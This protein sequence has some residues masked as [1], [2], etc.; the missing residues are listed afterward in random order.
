MTIEVA[1]P[2]V[3]SSLADSSTRGMIDAMLHRLEM[4]RP[5]NLLKQRFYDFDAQI[6][7]SKVLPAAWQEAKQIVGWPSTVVDVLEE[8]LDL[9][10][11]RGD[12]TGHLQALMDDGLGLEVSLAHLDALIYGISFVAVNPNAADDAE[13]DLV[14]AES[15]LN[16]TGIL[17]GRG[18]RLEAAIMV[19]ERD[20]TTRAPRAIVWADSSE[21]GRLRLVAGVWRWEDRRPHRLGVTPVVQL[22]NRPRASRL[23]GR[24]EISRPIRAYTVQSVQTLAGMSAN[25]DF[26]S[27]PQRWASNAPKDAFTDPDTGEDIP[28]WVTAM[29]AMLSMSSPGPGQPETRFGSFAT[30]PPGPF[31]DQIEGLAKQVAGEAAIP[32]H[33]LGMLTNNT[34]SAEAIKN[35]ESRLVKRTERR[36]ATFGRSWNQV[37]R[38]VLAARGLSAGVSVVWRAADTP[39]V[40]AETDAVVKLVQA[41]VLPAASQVTWDRLRIS[42]ADQAQLRADIAADAGPVGVL[43]SALGRQLD[44]GRAGHEDQG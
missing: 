17:D 9:L 38:M 11:W 40:A 10:G 29:A 8:R 35:I 14:T 24:S 34:A 1:A 2:L 4:T 37:G 27:Y 42:R 18:R 13:D 31:L 12:D 6:P 41:G 28:G 3:R 20:P 22:V 32:P 26:Y 5:S 7:K 19:A 43:A 44:E 39:T 33:Y 30:N 15:P 16:T 21:T 36:Q 23:G 25:R